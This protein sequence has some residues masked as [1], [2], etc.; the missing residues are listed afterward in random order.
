MTERWVEWTEITDSGDGVVYIRPYVCH[1]G[2][3]NLL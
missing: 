1:G 2:K 3:L